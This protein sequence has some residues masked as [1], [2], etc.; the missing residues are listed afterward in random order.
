VP[1]VDKTARTVARALVTHYY[2]VYGWPDKLISDNGKEFANQLNAELC[3]ALGIAQRFS[4]PYHPASN[5]Q[6]ERSHREVLV[7][8]RSVTDPN[9]TRWDLDLAYVQFAVNTTWTRV[10]G[11]TPFFLTFGRHPRTAVEVAIGTKPERLDTT[12]WLDRLRKAREVAAARSGLARGLSPP[13]QRPEEE[14]PAALLKVGELVLVRFT[15]VKEGLSTKLAKRQQGPYRVTKV[16]DDG[17]TA[18]L[19]HVE[20][21]TDTLRRHVSALFRFRS[22]GAP[23]GTE[24]P[25]T[26]DEHEGDDEFEVERI[27]DEKEINGHTEFLVRWAGFGKDH[28]SWVHKN[29][30][31]APGV[32]EAWRAEKQRQIA[33]KVVVQRV[34]GMRVTDQGDMLYLVEIDETA[35]P[36]GYRWVHQDE[37]RN[38]SVLQN[39]PR[40]EPAVEARSTKVTKAMEAK[41]P[42]G[43]SKAKAAPKSKA[44]PKP[45]TTTKPK[46]NPTQ[47]DW[48][49]VDRNGEKR[50]SPQRRED[51]D[52]ASTERSRAGRVRKPNSRYN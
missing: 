40:M 7:I 43:R 25:A 10:T 46:V 30:L 23:K 5:G 1:I 21:P 50:V 29:K 24:T 26:D 20:R 27:V 45:R 42:K 33:A 34:H 6:V 36:D 22:A 17:M 28:D 3:D 32:L 4:A 18:D 39:A 14:A 51:E 2:T 52:G 47:A 48:G 16:Y 11:M 15:G 19:Q 41:A 8:L 38:L 49:G 31:F 35:G 12:E 13:E 9:Q 44:A 37:V